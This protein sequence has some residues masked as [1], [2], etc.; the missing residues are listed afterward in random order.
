MIRSKLDFYFYREADRIISGR[1]KN[2]SNYFRFDPIGTFMYFL[3]SV[4]YYENCR[5]DLFGRLIKKYH[6][7]RFKRISLKLGFSIPTNVFG[8]GLYI[9]HYGTIVVNHNCLVG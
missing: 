5:T 2:F 6:S 8:P 1:N 7:Y 3:R 9:P 4:E